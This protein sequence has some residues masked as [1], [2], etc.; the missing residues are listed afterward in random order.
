M[1]FLDHLSAAAER[2]GGRPPGEYRFYR[3]CGLSRND[4]WAAGFDTY[5]AACKAIGHEPNVLQQRLND[6]SLFKPLAALTAELGRFP[7][8]GACEVRRKRDPQFP[9]WEVFQRRGRQ[10]PEIDLRQGLVAWCR[11]IGGFE[12]VIALLESNA[13]SPVKAGRRGAKA[14]VNGYVY[15]MRYGSG[16]SVFKVGL[17]DNV[18]RRHSQVSMMAP[19]DVRLVHSIATDDPAGIERYWLD[20]FAAKLVPGK[21]EL[22]RLTPDDVAAFKTRKYQ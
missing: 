7:S 16:G 8:K 22:F 18:H 20:R 10:G 12:Q 4:L 11:R 19:Q 21:K 6:D 17:T 2:N 15:L 14:V 3:E 5:G 13:S 9:S 1:T